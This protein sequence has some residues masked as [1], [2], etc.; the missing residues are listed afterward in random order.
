MEN[1]LLPMVIQQ[2]APKINVSLTANIPDF[3]F[4]ETYRGLMFLLCVLC[5]IPIKSI[6]GE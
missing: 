6:K 2:S 3:D 5:D 4:C 1:K